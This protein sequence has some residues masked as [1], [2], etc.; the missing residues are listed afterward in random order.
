MEVSEVPALAVDA[1]S[2][3]AYFLKLCGID[4]T[5]EFPTDRD[6]V[7]HFYVGATAPSERPIDL[8]KEG[9]VQV[10]WHVLEDMDRMDDGKPLWPEG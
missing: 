8:R 1:D 7:R 3:D 6:E 10:S 9:R 5:D 4:S 2:A